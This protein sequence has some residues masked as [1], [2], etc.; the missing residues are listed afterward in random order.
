MYYLAYIK[1][2]QEFL[3]SYHSG[4]TKVPTENKFSSFNPFA[5]FKDN[6]TSQHLSGIVST[7]CLIYDL[8]KSSE[9]G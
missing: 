8:M 4:L 6:T 5:K 9:G 2:Q 7:I 3:D 1:N